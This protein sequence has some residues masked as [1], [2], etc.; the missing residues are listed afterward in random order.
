[1]FE[2]DGMACYQWRTLGELT[3]AGCNLTA[4]SVSGREWDGEEVA[5]L[6][7]SRLNALQLVL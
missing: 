3:T 4:L 5:W 2:K 1:V 6:T 7:C